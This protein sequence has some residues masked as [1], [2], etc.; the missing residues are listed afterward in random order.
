[1]LTEDPGLV[2]ITHQVVY[3]CL[4]VHTQIQLALVFFI[5]Q[6]TSPVLL[7]DFSM[8]CS[9]SSKYPNVGVFAFLFSN[10]TVHM[11]LMIQFE[12]VWFLYYLM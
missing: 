8:L 3:N 12:V 10:F 11:D 7:P 6:V 9:K 1:A 5:L 2:S 4:Q